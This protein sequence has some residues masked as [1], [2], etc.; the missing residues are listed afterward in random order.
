AICIH[1]APSRIQNRGMDVLLID[2]QARRRQ[3]L[4]R[5]LSG[6][7]HDVR[8]AGGPVSARAALRRR[9]PQLVALDGGMPGLPSGDLLAEMEKDPRICGA[10]VILFARNAGPLLATAV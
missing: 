6:R 8:T 5:A 1:K 2:A 10:R 7:G 4:A 9:T 3:R